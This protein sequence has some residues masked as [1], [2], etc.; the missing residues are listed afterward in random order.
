MIAIIGLLFSFITILIVLNR[1]RSL[2]LAMLSGSM[3]LALT[4]GFSLEL[5]LK[6]FWESATDPSTLKLVSV[7]VLINLLGYIL[8]RTKAL[9]ALVHTIILGLK[10]IRLVVVV[11]PALIGLLPVPGGAVM[12]APMAMEA[13][14]KAGISSEKQAAANVVFRHLVYLIFPLHATLILAQDLSGIGML[15]FIS[16]QI[17]PM[18]VGFVV[19]FYALF[20]N[21]KRK[22]E[23]PAI[24]EQWA[25]LLAKF[26]YYS[27]PIYS[28]IILVTVFKVNFVL[29]AAAGV[30]LAILLGIKSTAQFLDRVKHFVLPGLGWKLAVAVMGILIFRGYVQESGAIET[31]TLHFQ[32]MGVP[33][34]LLAVIFPLLMGIITGSPMAAVGITI[35]IFVSLI[36]IG[37]DSIKIFSLIYISSLA[38]YVLS[39]LHMCLMLTREVCRANLIG[40]YPYLIIPMAG[41]L[42]TSIIQFFL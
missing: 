14:K 13:G 17:P 34:L 38:G 35:P 6:I 26:L 19:C 21:T 36:P 2:G 29:S 30:L 20:K 24:K 42:M 41:L 3:V 32:Q 18:I 25:G 5:A 11:V 28:I 40:I 8:N 10:D 16:Y 31:I 9:E 12:S 22:I 7:V 4:G 27:L 1:W 23:P 33:V 15:K 37:M 39:P